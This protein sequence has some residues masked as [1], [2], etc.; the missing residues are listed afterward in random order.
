MKTKMSIFSKIKFSI[1]CFAFVLSS[2]SAN[3][4]TPA[5][6]PYYFVSDNVDGASQ[7]YSE[8]I[9]SY[10]GIRMTKGI[11]LLATVL[12]DNPSNLLRSGQTLVPTKSFDILGG[13]VVIQP[14]AHTVSGSTRKINLPIGSNLRTFLNDPLGGAKFDLLLPFTGHNVALSANSGALRLPGPG[15]IF[16]F[17]IDFDVST[18]NTQGFDIFAPADGII[19]GNSIAS[20][21]SSMAIRHTASNGKPFLTYYQHLVPR[22]N[23]LAVGATITRGAKVTRKKYTTRA[24]HPF[25]G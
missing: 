2:L 4:Q 7:Y 17:G 11:N 15:S 18:D 3:A 25:W 12:G 23:N 1:L 22:S 24:C 21:G 8:G 5:P 14:F 16:H 19:E 10:G 9:E 13:S 6:G 20:G